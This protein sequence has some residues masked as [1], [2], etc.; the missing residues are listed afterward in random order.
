MNTVWV[1]RSCSFVAAGAVMLFASC[2]AYGPPRVTGEQI[3]RGIVFASP[4]GHDLKLDLY[5]PPKS[6]NA[7]RPAPVVMWI[8]GGSWRFGTRGYHVNIRDL[9][10]AGIAVASIDY[11]YSSE[12]I[13]PAQ[14]D[15]CRAALRWLETHGAAYGLDPGRIGVA[16][17]SAGGH[18]AALLGVIEGRPRIRAVVALY[19]PTDLV[20]IGRQYADAN[21]SDIERLL[22]GSIEDR[23]ALARAASP[24]FHVK[25][26]SPPFLLIHGSLDDLVTPWHSE[27]IDRRLRAAGVESRVILVPDQAHWF[28]LTALQLDVVAKYFRRHFN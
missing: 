22:G 19:P 23:L 5:V 28:D 27:E 16:G 3:H 4:G 7:G 2:A 15:D 11:R 26:D 24:V 10:R 9:T 14:L 12:A 6:A 20:A 17:E 8:F 13:F 25:A 18:L 21:P 1:F